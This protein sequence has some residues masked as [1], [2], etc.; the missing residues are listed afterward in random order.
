MI[1]TVC[2]NPLQYKGGEN[3]EDFGCR[4]REGCPSRSEAHYYP[5]V[6]VRDGWYF[7]ASYN[8]PFL[9]QGK[10][11]CLVG[12]VQDYFDLKKQ[13]KDRTLLQEITITNFLYPSSNQKTL[14]SIPYMALPTNGDFYRE[15]LVLVEKAMSILLVKE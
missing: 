12:P 8:L 11:F 6:K 13:F 10:W 4:N 1:C 15:F 9:W 5:N 7:A 2:K 3:K 14:V